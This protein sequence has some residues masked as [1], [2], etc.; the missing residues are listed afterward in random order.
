MRLVLP[1][2]PDRYDPVVFAQA[3]DEI[4]RAVE[5]AWARGEDVVLV[6]TRDRLVLQS[7][8]GSRFHVTVDNAGVLGT[9][10]L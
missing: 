3:M 5:K 8:D 4:A 6:G 1:P 10:A 7:P 9:T 2:P